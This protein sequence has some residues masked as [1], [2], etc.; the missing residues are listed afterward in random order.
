MRVLVTGGTGFVGRAT[1][2]GLASAGHA[3]RVVARP[4]SNTAALPGD[5]ELVRVADLRGADWGALVRDI[6]AVVW[7]AARVHVMRETAADPVAEFR[8]LNVDAPLACARALRAGAGFVYM[9]SIKVNGECTSPD[10]PFTI[11]S[12]PAPKDRYAVSKWQ[13]ERGL[14]TVC[15]DRGAWLNVLR[16]PLVYGPGVGGNF[17]RMF[18]LV[19]LAERV[20]LPF[21]GLRNRRSL[22]YVEDLADAVRCAVEHPAA[23][24]AP[25]TCLVAG[26]EAPS[27]TELLCALAA[28]LDA[29]PHLVAVPSVL[30]ALARRLPAV[31]PSVA[32]LTQSLVVDT[33]AAA[34]PIGWTPRTDLA[35]GLRAT[36]AWWRACETRVDRARG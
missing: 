27:T 14:A 11:D 25:K 2:R 34:R 23:A 32:R 29:A 19:R 10:A 13:G 36:T 33:S 3:L 5:A 15:Y 8:A 21:G 22:V 17:V 4:M 12:P 9:S 18:D 30:F 7:L 26:L 1:V 28:A 20:P 24:A 35:T 31:G 6:D 16:P